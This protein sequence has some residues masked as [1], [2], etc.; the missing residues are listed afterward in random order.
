[1]NEVTDVRFHPPIFMSSDVGRILEL[2]NACFIPK[3]WFVPIHNLK[4]L[5]SYQVLKN[6]IRTTRLF[7]YKLVYLHCKDKMVLR[8]I[9]EL[10]INAEIGFTKIEQAIY[11]FISRKCYEPSETTSYKIKKVKPDGGLKVERL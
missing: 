4:Y 3:K 6:L 7:T 5:D 2:N 11:S 1:M 9:V 8:F 10:C